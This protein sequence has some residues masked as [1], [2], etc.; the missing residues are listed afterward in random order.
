MLKIVPKVVA[1]IVQLFYLIAYINTSF[2][3]CNMTSH[4]GTIRSP[5]L[6]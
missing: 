4:K 3:L 1:K 5:N 2:L 6:S